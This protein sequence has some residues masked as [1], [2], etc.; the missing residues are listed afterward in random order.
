LYQVASYEANVGL[1]AGSSTLMRTGIS[2]ATASALP[3]QGALTDAG[4]IIY[5]GG[6]CA[7][8]GPLQK[9]ID[10]G[11]AVNGPG[12]SSTGSLISSEQSLAW[13]TNE[14]VAANGIDWL[15]Q[16]YRFTNAVLQSIGTKIDGSGNAG[17]RSLQLAGWS[18]G[19]DTSGLTLTPSNQVAI[20]PSG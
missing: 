14:S 10:F 17:F 20:A 4:L 19:L 11:M 5:C 18:F 8:G 1:P 13:P 2:I 15:T 16:P 9:G 7:T 6:S 12:I 3:V